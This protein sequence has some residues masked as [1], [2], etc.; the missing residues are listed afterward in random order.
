MNMERLCKIYTIFHKKQTFNAE[1]YEVLSDTR[2]EFLC[3]LVSS[4]SAKH[5]LSRILTI[6]FPLLRK[7]IIGKD[8]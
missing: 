2:D 7:I 5:S 1:F 8:D 4:K 3:K 6:F